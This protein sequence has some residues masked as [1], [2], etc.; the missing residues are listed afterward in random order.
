ME[1]DYGVKNMFLKEISIK[2]N[3]D[4]DLDDILN[5]FYI[6]VLSNSI[7]YKRLAGFFSSSSLAISAKGIVRF[8]FNGGHMQLICG[9]KLSKSDIEAI[10]NAYETPEEVIERIMLKDLECL[11]E[12]FIRDHVRALGWMVASKR[13]EIKVAIGINEEGNLLDENRV[14]KQA[15]FH[16][17]VGILE[18]VGGNI[19]SFS[20]SEN[21]SASGWQGNIEEFKVFR[22]WIVAERP[23]L[24]ADVEKF[25]RFWG[26]TARRTLVME[27]PR[28]VKK[29]LIEIAP[30]NIEDLKLERWLDKRV[31]V[32]RGVKLW[33]HQNQAITNWLNNGKKGIF[34]MAT[35]TGKT[36]AALGCLKK[37]MEERDRLITVIA[38]PYDHLI[39]QWA[40]D[41]KEIEIQCPVVIADSSNPDWKDELADCL[42]DIKNGIG[43]KL[44]VLTTHATFPRKDFIKIVRISNEEKFVIVDEVH[45]IGAPERKL[46]LIEDYHF[47]LGLS[48]TPKRWFDIEGTERLFEYFGDTV[49]EFSLKDAIEKINP[50]TGET[51]LVPYEYKPYFVE[52]TDGELERYEVETKKIAK[53]YHRAK[54]DEEREKWFSLLCFRRQE[55]IKNAVNKYESF[56]EILHELGKDKIKH[57]LVYCSPEQIDSVQDL[58]NEMNIIQH[59]FT[60]H[61]GTTPKEEFNGLSEREFLLQKFAEGAYQVLVAIKCLDEGV[62]VPPARTAIIL[63]ST[64][65][66]RE[67]I[68][69]RGRILRRFPGKDKAIIHDVIVVPYLSEPVG[70]DLLDIERKILQ[71]E[72][73]RYREFAGIAIN[74]LE[75]LN[76]IYT[77]EKKFKV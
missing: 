21:E 40:D 57:C 55:I 68:Q 77:V 62:D 46:G 70:D 67:W 36:F 53:A 44:I 50:C 5:D 60:L 73:R 10:K 48:A 23:Y 14:E 18:D 38:C 41:I 33:D 26:G 2:N 42:L 74:S 19:L 22:S 31:K 3:Y 66:P 71:K 45:G 6:P 35:G 63:A 15:I 17:K 13:L 49:F 30:K 20:G 8:I 12:D 32:H 4:S 76:K 56:R 75:C 29:K 1:Y 11:E 47:R 61:E 51:Y 52:L 65:N 34:E 69:R 58:L 25:G 54:D 37:V 59:K 72:L 24:E 9:A 64:G 27:I 7:K 28:A 16:Q 39:K 43:E